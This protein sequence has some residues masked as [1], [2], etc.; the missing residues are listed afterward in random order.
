MNVSYHRSKFLL[1][2]LLGCAL[3]GCGGDD[4]GDAAN[5]APSDDVD[6][7]VELAGS[8]GDGPV[9]SRRAPAVAKRHFSSA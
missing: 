9:V 2:V 8:V 6:L 7:D 5:D 4:S 3:Q 1:C